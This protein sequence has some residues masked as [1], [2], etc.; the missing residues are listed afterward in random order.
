MCRELEFQIEEIREKDGLFVDRDIPA[1]F[2]QEAMEPGNHVKKVHLKAA[3]SVGTDSILAE[4]S[5]N[6]ELEL[7]CA[8]CGEQFETRFN[9]DF[10]ETY[11]FCEST[12]NLRNIIYDILAL[13]AGIQSLC[14]DA[15]RGRCPQCGANLNHE[16]CDC[17]SN[18]P[19]P[20]AAIRVLGNKEKRDA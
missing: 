6:A 5:I 8:R 16:T 19:N 15:C 11:E 4:G 2:F 1:S 12:I 7:L 3:F 13:S 20:F 14:S 10:S 9:E 17:L 18:M